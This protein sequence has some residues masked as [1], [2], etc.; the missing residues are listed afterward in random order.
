MGLFTTI[1]IL[2]SDFSSVSDTLREAE[3]AGATMIHW[4][5]MDGH[6][7]PNLTF[8]SKL[9][10]DCRKKSTLAFDTHL[11]I[12]SPSDYLDSFLACSDIITFHLEANAQPGALLSRIRTAGK[13][14]GLAINPRTPLSLL[15]PFLNDLDTL[16]LM[17]VE[18]GFG[19]QPIGAAVGERL[20]TLVQMR[21]D[22]DAS[23]TIVVD[24]GVHQG[25]AAFL[26][27]CGADGVVL[28]SS[29]TASE[30]KRKLIEAVSQSE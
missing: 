12:S 22:A 17:G 14:A 6:F 4:D 27:K 20:S 1:S 9:I 26:R 30:N 16:L 8:G 19:G 18:P 28:G 23:F 15:T 13:K 2:S 25:N 24:G 3:E 10:A 29:F 21:H 5:V 11:M 7:V